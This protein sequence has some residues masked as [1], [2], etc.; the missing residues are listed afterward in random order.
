[1]AHFYP[2]NLNLLGE[3]EGMAGIAILYFLSIY[4]SPQVSKFQKYPHKT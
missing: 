1:M 4:S 2:F 3:N